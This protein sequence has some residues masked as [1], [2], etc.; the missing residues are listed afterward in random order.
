M[1][2]FEGDKIKA[3]QAIGVYAIRRCYYVTIMKEYKK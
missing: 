2:M 1:I 3:T